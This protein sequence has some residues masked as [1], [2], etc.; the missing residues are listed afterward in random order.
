MNRSR[1]EA[2]ATT[3]LKVLFHPSSVGGQN[4]LLLLI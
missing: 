2:K 4:I 1:V 3:I